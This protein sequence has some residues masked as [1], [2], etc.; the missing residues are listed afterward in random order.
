MTP[1]NCSARNPEDFFSGIFLSRAD[2]PAQHEVLGQEYGVQDR[3]EG[4]IMSVPQRPFIAPDRRWHNTVVTSQALAA[5][6]RRITNK[7]SN[8]GSSSTNTMHGKWHRKSGIRWRWLRACV[9]APRFMRSSR[10]LESMGHMS[11]DF[12]SDSLHMNRMS[13]RYVP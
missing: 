11:L 8:G 5:R 6:R 4:T 13:H 1:F 10:F 7:N 9:A 2:N 12:R 3:S